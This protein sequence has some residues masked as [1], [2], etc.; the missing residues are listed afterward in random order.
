MENLFR[1]MKTG[2]QVIDAMTKQLVSVSADTSVFDCAVLMRKEHVGSII[3]EEK[4]AIDGIVTEQ[5][6]LYKIVCENKDPKNTKVR[7]IMTHDVAIIN[8]D[9]DIADAM[10]KMSQLNIRRLPVVEEGKL[11][12][13]LTHKDILKIEPQLFELLVDKLELREEKN[14]PI[15]RIGEKEGICQLCGEYATFLFEQDSVFVCKECRE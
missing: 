6:M 13:M 7:E 14:K 15:N 10:I 2:L 3:V 12:G 11:V 8:P 4:G 5:D 1:V 9:N